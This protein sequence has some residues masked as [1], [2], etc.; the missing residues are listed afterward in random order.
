MDEG[1]T[2]EPAYSGYPW[3]TRVTVSEK[4]PVH[5][6]QVE[7]NTRAFWDLVTWLLWRGDLPI[8]T[9]TNIIKVHCSGLTLPIYEWRT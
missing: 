6:M 3:D 9:V 8:V 1:Y 2:V 5:Y 4:L 7:L